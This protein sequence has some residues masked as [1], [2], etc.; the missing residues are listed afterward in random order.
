M[1]D[2]FKKLLRVSSALVL[3]TVVLLGTATSSASASGPELDDVEQ[4]QPGDP[5]LDETLSLWPGQSCTFKARAHNPHRSGN[6]ASGH[7]SWE[8]TSNP[9]SNCPNTALVRVQLQAWQCHPYNPFDCSWYTRAERTQTK[10]SGQRVAVH[11]PCNTFETASW[12]TRVT[13]KV[14]I[15]G[16]FDKR[17]TRSNVK[18]VDC[19]V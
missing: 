14:I 17:N 13:V 7:G 4:P 12:R 11:Y 5:D 19:R 15:S 2:R 16:W 1:R 10:Y 9:A 18:N 8:N 3:A 6:D